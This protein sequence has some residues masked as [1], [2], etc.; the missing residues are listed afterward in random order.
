MTLVIWTTDSGISRCITEMNATDVYQTSILE[1]WQCGQI[2]LAAHREEGPSADR[3]QRIGF[4]CWVV[5][6]AACPNAA[7]VLHL[8]T[9]ENNDACTRRRRIEGVSTPGKHAMTS[10]RAAVTPVTHSIRIHENHP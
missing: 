5:I 8:H 10:K 9:G 3:V 2:A 6:S 7:A 1:A 4:D